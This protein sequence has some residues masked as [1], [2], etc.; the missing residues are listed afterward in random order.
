ML[1]QNISVISGGP[2][3]GKTQTIRELA[4]LGYRTGSEFARELIQ[5]QLQSGGDMLPWKNIKAFQSEILN[6]RIGFYQSVGEHELAFCDRAIP[7]QL[8]FA[9]FRGFEPSA[10]LWKSARLYR[11]AETVFVAPPWREIYTT[12]Q[13]RNENF[14]EA[15][16]LHQY[17]CDTYLELGYQLT[18]LPLTDTASRA[19]FIIDQ[20]KLQNK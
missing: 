10:L 8:A 6:R 9:R 7:D 12:D 5:Q 15:C 2:G 11:Y 16:L 13:T 18:E 1:K 3:F 19:R 4:N 20:L 14:E 17:I